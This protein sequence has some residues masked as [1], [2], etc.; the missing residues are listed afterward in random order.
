MRWNVSSVNLVPLRD[1]W[2]FTAIVEGRVVDVQHRHEQ[3]VCE[4]QVKAEADSSRIEQGGFMQ[5]IALGIGEFP[6]QHVGRW[7]PR[8]IGPAW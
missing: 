6:F 2:I 7:R 8:Q 4:R 5:N 1:P 3:G